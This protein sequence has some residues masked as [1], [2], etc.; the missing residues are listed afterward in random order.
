MSRFVRLGP[1]VLALV[2]GLVLAPAV[3]GDGAIIN[4]KGR[5]VPE[6]EQQAVIEWHDGQERLYVATRADPAGGP[7]LWMVPV[8]ASPTQVRA[9]PAEQ[10]PRV[11]ERGRVVEPALSK[12]REAI[13]LTCLLDSGLFPCLFFAASGGKDAVKKDGVEEFQRV[14]RLGMVVVVLSV[15]S[16]EAL[17]RYLAENGVDARAADLSALKPYLGS[18]EY[19]LVCGWATQAAKKVSARALRIDF[20]SPVV[21]YPLRPTRVYDSDVRTALFVRGLVR[22]VEGISLPG[23][24][25]DYLQGR[26]DEPRAPR[27]DK[28][29]LEPITRVELTSPPASWDQDLVL[30]AGAPVAVKAALFIGDLSLDHLWAAS[31]VVGAVLALFLPWVVLPKGARRLT[32]WVWATVV[33]ASI[34]LTVYASALAFVAWRWASAP[35]EGPHGGKRAGWML[36]GVAFGLALI[37]VAMLITMVAPFG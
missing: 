15:Q 17:D 4:K 14:E 25:C 27:D 18:K 9:E 30:E 11:Y 16:P 23:L 8:R 24:R 1:V 6:R 12:L 7:S 3:R 21:F 28:A 19:A 5:Y 32:D 26:I 29:K 31:G 33:G 22:P 34:C 35:R 20:P 36:V 37:L 13:F 2:S 10:L